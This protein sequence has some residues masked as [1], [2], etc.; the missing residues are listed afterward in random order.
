MYFDPPIVVVVNEHNCSI[1]ESGIGPDHRAFSIDWNSINSISNGN[2]VYCIRSAVD[3]MF[4][5]ALRIILYRSTF[6][7]WMSNYSLRGGVLQSIE[8]SLE[9]RVVH[10]CRSVLLTFKYWLGKYINNK[11]VNQ[12]FP[13][14]PLRIPFWG[15][16]SN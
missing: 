7:F 3:C 4:L 10:L 13:R 11:S 15:Y 14:L 16:L 5:G 9:W 12:Q 1:S 6:W 2:Q 8:F